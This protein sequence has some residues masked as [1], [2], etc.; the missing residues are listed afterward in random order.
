MKSIIEAGGYDF[1]VHHDPVLKIT[2]DGFYQWFDA[3]KDLVLTEMK[4]ISVFLLLEQPDG[5][6]LKISMRP[7]LFKEVAAGL[8][9]IIEMPTEPETPDA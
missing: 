9:K 8:Q 5:S 2:S 7:S 1:I 6:F 4:I 3:D